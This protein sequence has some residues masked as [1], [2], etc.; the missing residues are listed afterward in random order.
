M[1][2]TIFD[3][4]RSY[5]PS[6]GRDPKED[7][8]TQLFAWLLINVKGLD[9][10]YCEYLLK[11]T[12][13]STFTVKAS[14][15]ITVETQRTLDN[16]KRIDLLITVNDDNGFIC[17]HKIYSM[18][19]PNQITNYSSMAPSLGAGQFHTVLITLG[20]YQWTQPADV[21]ILWSGI[22]QDFLQ[23]E[24]ENYAN[25]SVNYFML[26]QTISFMQNNSL[27]TYG[28][29]TSGAIA[30]YWETFGLKD[31]VNNIIGDLRVRD[32]KT[33]C[34]KLQDCNTQGFTEPTYRKERWGRVGLEMY[35]NWK[36][37]PG[38]FAG[39]LWDPSNHRI[40]PLNKEN[41]GPDVVILVDLPE[42]GYAQVTSTQ[43]CTDYFQKLNQEHG[44]FD[45][46]HYPEP[47]DHWRLIVLRKSLGDVLQGKQNRK[48]QEDALYKTF[49][50]GINFLTKD[51]D[52]GRLNW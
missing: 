12:S 28:E 9:L 36:P 27:G 7:Y 15:K 43:A 30:G 39:I 33:D 19:S 50:E 6:A 21:R 16:G 18:L 44:D 37:G 38:I 47:K 49:C 42:V 52:L 14:D 4:L 51:G 2:D 22:Y 1:N 34:K 23:K 45:L 48:E 8:L 32:W 5:V 17:E 35:N 46:I 40:E 24:L 25:D 41:S 20:T 26:D 29:V 11:K 13:N 3:F 31:V 10:K